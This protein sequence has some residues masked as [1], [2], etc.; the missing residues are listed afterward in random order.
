MLK[1][2]EREKQRVRLVLLELEG[3]F[4]LNLPFQQPDTDQSII[5]GVPTQVNIF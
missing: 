1:V 4:Q 3:M 5:E 2:Y